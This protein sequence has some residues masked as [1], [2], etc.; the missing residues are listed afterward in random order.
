MS[1]VGKLVRN[2]VPRLIAESGREP[3]T[4]VVPK[5]QLLP[6]LLAKLEEECGELSSNPGLDELVD[7]LEILAII[8]WQLEIPAQSILTALRDKRRT[9]GS[10][11]DSIWLE[12]VSEYTR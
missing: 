3:T 9:H 2:K 1:K 5:E 4:Q 10:F 7:V 12:A 8:S 6:V 11:S